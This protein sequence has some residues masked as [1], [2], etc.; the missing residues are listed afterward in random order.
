MASLSSVSSG[1]TSDDDISMV[2]P[3]I[4]T[5]DEALVE[6]LVLLG[7]E[8]PQLERRLRST[9]VTQYKSMFGCDPCVVAQLCEYLQTTYIAEAR[10]EKM[11]TDKYMKV[12]HTNT[13]KF[14][15]T[16]SLPIGIGV[17]I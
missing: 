11:E 5:E 7:W 14:G 9:N 8:L 1:E 3:I 4:M 10:I 17:W 2:P 15:L 16:W 12:D 6:G 13:L